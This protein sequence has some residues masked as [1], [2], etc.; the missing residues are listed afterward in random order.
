MYLYCLGMVPSL[1]T[2]SNNYNED[3]IDAGYISLL[4]RH[5]ISFYEDDGSSY[6]GMVTPLLLALKSLVTA[7]P[8]M[9]EELKVN[10]TLI[11]V[12]YSAVSSSFGNYSHTAHLHLSGTILMCELGHDVFNSVIHDRLAEMRTTMVQAE[13]NLKV[14]YKEQ[15]NRVMDCAAQFSL[16]HESYVR[17]TEAIQTIKSNVFDDD[18]IERSLVNLRMLWSKNPKSRQ[19][20]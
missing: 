14:H 12:L 16:D 17:S 4:S 2:L 9:K 15:I 7:S 13:E 10:M 6:I 18:L 19:L 5:L 3:F 20:I 8:E 11:N 1:L